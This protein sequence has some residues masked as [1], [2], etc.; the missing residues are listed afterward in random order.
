MEISNMAFHSQYDYLSN[1][2]NDTLGSKYYKIKQVLK[3]K[4]NK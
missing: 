4:T 1:N 3:K 2:V